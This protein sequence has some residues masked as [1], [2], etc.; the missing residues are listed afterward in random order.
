MTEEAVDQIQSALGMKLPGLYR[1]VMASGDALTAKDFWYG[2]MFNAAEVVVERTLSMRE[3]L[4]SF[5][6][7][8]P[9]SWIVVSEVNGGDAV[10]ID[11]ND[12]DATLHYLDHETMSLDGAT[13]SLSLFVESCRNLGL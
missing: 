8:C 11:A 3:T 9:D 7:D 6:K 13:D 10:I 5:G 12:S 4:R 1:Q 2:G